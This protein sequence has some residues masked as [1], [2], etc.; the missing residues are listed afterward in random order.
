VR[1]LRSLSF[2]LLLVALATASGCGGGSSDDNESSGGTTSSG[3]TSTT[4]G[5]TDVS[6][7]SPRDESDHT[8][9]TS[10]LDSGKTYRVAVQTNCG[11]F[12][13]TLDQ[14]GSPKTSASFVSLVEDGYFD[15]T[16][17][18]RIAPGF[19]IQGGDPTGKGSGGPGYTTVE[20]PP[21][22]ASYVKYVVAMAK[23]SAEPPG[24]AGSQFF[25]VTA[26]DAQLPPEYALLGKVTDGKD[27]VDRI[28][29]LGDPSTEQP[30]RPVVIQ[31]MSVET[32]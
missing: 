21:A 9:P 24:A 13:I 14:K 31:K 12:T 4:G 7:P 20:P 22:G 5:C 3:G 26:P 18:H 25:V 29:K 17:F 30:T 10:P 6:T 23:T 8:A 28:G 11:E 32:S 15:D 27:V 2:V 16:T 19:V 1:L